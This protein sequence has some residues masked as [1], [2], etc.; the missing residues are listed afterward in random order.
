MPA[1]QSFV[2]IS[3]RAMG[4]RVAIAPDYIE[5]MNSQRTSI[6]NQIINVNNGTRKKTSKVKGAGIGELEDINDK[7][8]HS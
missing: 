4:P 6:R 8:M 7:I 5:P 2:S 3:P 1:G